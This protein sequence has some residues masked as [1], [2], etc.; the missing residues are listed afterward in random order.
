M[1]L[2]VHGNLWFECTREATC[3]T[4]WS[5]LRGT[6]NGS[7]GDQP[8]PV[9]QWLRKPCSGTR[10]LRRFFYCGCGPGAPGSGA[11]SSGRDLGW[12]T[13]RAGQVATVLGVLT[14]R[15]GW[16]TGAGW[17]LRFWHARAEVEVGQRHPPGL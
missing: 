13:S 10:E 15:A 5:T 4:V 16:L 17:L 8:G 9:L 7:V 3:G 14:E 1:W 6:N 2:I 12:G 11:G